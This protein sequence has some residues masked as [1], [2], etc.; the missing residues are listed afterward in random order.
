MILISSVEYSATLGRRVVGMEQGSKL[1]ECVI[2]PR[3]W[4]FPSLA[5]LAAGMLESK[6][7]TMWSESVIPTLRE[8]DAIGTMLELQCARHEVHSEEKAKG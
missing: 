5:L 7:G 3:D 2:D 8:K 1:E 6:R 4:C